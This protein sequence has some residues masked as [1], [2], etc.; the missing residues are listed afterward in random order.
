MTPHHL[1]RPC[2]K[3]PH[4]DNTFRP[5]AKRDLILTR[6][7]RLTTRVTTSF[8]YEVMLHTPC[9]EGE[10][11]HGATH[12]HNRTIDDMTYVILISALGCPPRGL[13]LALGSQSQGCMKP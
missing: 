9:L 8:D 4:L 6:S 11:V 12:E 7:L 1:P 10:N 3:K 5:Y 2:I 13:S